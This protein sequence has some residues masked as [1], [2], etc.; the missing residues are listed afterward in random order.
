MNGVK[1]RSTGPCAKKDRFDWKG[2][3]CRKGLPASKADVLG[4]AQHD[5]YLPEQSPV[6]QH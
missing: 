6:L 2:C 4:A 5:L 1:T 3:L